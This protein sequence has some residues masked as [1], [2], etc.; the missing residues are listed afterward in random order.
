MDYESSIWF[1]IWNSKWGRRIRN[2]DPRHDELV[3]F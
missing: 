2:R 3:E 1:C